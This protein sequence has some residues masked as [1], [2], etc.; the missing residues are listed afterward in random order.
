MSDYAPNPEDKRS[1]PRRRVL[2]EGLLV[3]AGGRMKLS[4]MVRDMSPSG[5]RIYVSEAVQ[6]PETFEFS[7]IGQQRRWTATV[8]WRKGAFV[9]LKLRSAESAVQAATLAAATPTV[10]ATMPAEGTTVT[11]L[12]ARIE[13]LEH[14][15]QRLR[16][17]LRELRS[18]YEP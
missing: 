12:L 9:G 6:V 2:F 5:A 8:R 10:H 13:E 7:I 3:G 14:E 18:R 15:N 11:D 4:C 17:K 16:K 1:E